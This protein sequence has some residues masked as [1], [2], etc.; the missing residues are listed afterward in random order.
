MNFSLAKIF[1]LFVALCNVFAVTVETMDEQV[2]SNNLTVLRLRINNKTDEPIYNTKIKF[3]VSGESGKPVVDAY[4]LGGA[5]L[6]V[7]SLNGSL[8]AVT[9]AVDTLPSGVFPYESGI[10]LGIHNK[11]WQPRDKS[12]DPSY[13]ASSSFIV[14]DRVE[15]NVDGNHLPDAEPL[16]LF[17]GM[18]IF[19]D[20]GDSVR[21]AW[22]SVPNAEKYRLSVYSSDSQLVYQKEMYEYTESVALEAGD[23]LWRVEAK[24]SLT[25]YGVVGAGAGAQLQSLSVREMIGFHIQEQKYFGV[26]SVSGHKDTPMLVV[27]WGEYAVLR[28]WDEPHLNRVFLDENEAFSCWAIAVKNLNMLYGGNLSLDEIRW[29]VKKNKVASSF[30]SI[31]AFGFLTEAEAFPYEIEIGLKYAL[32]STMSYARVTNKPLTYENVKL[33]LKNNQGVLIDISWGDKDNTHHIMLIDA[34]FTAVEG[35]ILR[36]VNVDNI[37]NYGYFLADSLLKKTSWYILVDAPQSVRN[38]NPLLGVEKYNLYDSWIEWTDSDGDGITDFDEVYRFGTNPRLADSDSDG[39]DDKDEILSYT[40]LEKSR[41]NL[42]GSYVGA[43]ADLTQMRFI[44]GIENEYMADVDGDGLRA[45]LDPDSD[46][47]GLLDGVDPDP[48]KPNGTN[49]FLEINELPKDVMLYAL[50]QLIVND[51]TTCSS[52][53]LDYCSYVSEDTSS[54]YGMFMGARTSAARLFARNNV[55]I[56]SNPENTFIVNYYG[57]D[58][59]A[60]ARPDGKMTID[61]HFR[62]ENWPWKLNI[63]L[64]S[65]DEGDSVLIVQSGDTCFLGDNDHFRMLKVESGGVVYFPVGNVYIGD[66]QLDAGSLVKFED[67]SRNTVLYVKGKILWKSRFSYKTGFGFTYDFVARHFKLVYSG[68]GRVFFDTNWYGTIIAPKARIILGQT[69]AKNLYGQFYANEIV[70]HQYSNLNLVPFEWEQGGLEYAFLYGMLKW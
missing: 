59:L 57:S 6:D 35:N 25:E 24:N 66:L 37:G 10:C 5:I 69:N 50:K 64:P 20:E 61:R 55:F 38:M 46:N 8:W 31:N 27:G 9:L 44:R 15:L 40:L 42:A 51:G 32:D 41:L 11:N 26:A 21:F 68:I 60:T 65:F 29:Y 3:F 33:H 54:D 53:M 36:C 18:R 56:R 58:N 48:Y 47:D 52:S 67:Q 4:D 19:L 12:R 13:I 17:S 14:N 62:A 16:V 70:I 1:V 23:Y 39:V 30:D 43:Y 7:D 34:F 49:E 2:N 28:E 63:V 45:E 22:H